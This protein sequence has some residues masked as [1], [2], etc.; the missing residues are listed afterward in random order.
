[1]TIE[2]IV[3]EARKEEEQ[4]EHWYDGFQR[5]T[6]EYHN[7]G[8]RCALDAVLRI[9]AA[10]APDP[11]LVAAREILQDEN[12]EKD[13]VPDLTDEERDAIRKLLNA[14]KGESQ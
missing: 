12:L 5:Q 4:I 3:A 10:Q 9:A 14:T 6:I 1:M 2:Q 13:G 11:E 7:D 8:F